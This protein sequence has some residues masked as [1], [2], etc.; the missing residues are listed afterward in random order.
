MIRS[1][2][3]KLGIIKLFDHEYNSTIQWINNLGVEKYREFR[4]V[5]SE[6]PRGE[7]SGNYKEILADDK[8]YYLLASYKGWKEEMVD[9]EITLLENTNELKGIINNQIKK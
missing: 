1:N 6:F 4:L 3:L 5:F 8:L 9:R 7:I 2:E